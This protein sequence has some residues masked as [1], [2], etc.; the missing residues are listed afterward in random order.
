MQYRIYQTDKGRWQ[1]QVKNWC[2]F[3]KIPIFYKWGPVT[4]QDF[5]SFDDAIAMLKKQA[6]IIETE[7]AIKKNRVIRNY[8]PKDLFKKD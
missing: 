3:L 2:Y 8:E 7:L 4:N 1:P 6:E 5:P